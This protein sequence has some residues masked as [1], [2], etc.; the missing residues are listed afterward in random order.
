[1]NAMMDSSKEDVLAGSCPAFLFVFLYVSL[2]VMI[3]Y[4]VSY[5]RDDL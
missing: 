4:D 3:Y 2:C 1:M 5:V